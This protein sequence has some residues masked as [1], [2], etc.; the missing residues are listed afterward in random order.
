MMMHGLTP[1]PLLFARNPDFVSAAF[2]SLTIASFVI[3]LYGVGGARL[4]ARFLAIPTHL[5]MPI[6]L[7]L[8]IVGS[9]AIRN[10]IFDVGSALV[11]GV[12]GYVMLKVDI[13]RPPL[14]LGYILGPLFE[15]NFRRSLI[16][17]DGSLI[18]YF[19]RPISLGVIIFTIL[20]LVSPYVLGGLGRLRR[21]DRRETDM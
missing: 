8:C 4:Y 3:L 2:I 19:T 17:G 1:G 14:I 16:L 18:P 15:D 12:L 13:A 9:F 10:S 7:L 5:L 11:L 21:K 6:I 20:I